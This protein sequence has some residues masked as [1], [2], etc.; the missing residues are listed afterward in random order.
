MVRAQRAPY[1][2][3]LGISPELIFFGSVSCSTYFFVSFTC[4]PIP[5]AHLGWGSLLGNG[6][7]WYFGLR[8]L[9]PFWMGRFPLDG[10]NSKGNHKASDQVAGAL[11]AFFF[12]S[13][14]I[15]A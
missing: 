2:M 12:V 15:F 11:F 3:L 14:G 4:G 10:Q 6:Q 1:N 7:G 13:C 9:I 8:G 5:K